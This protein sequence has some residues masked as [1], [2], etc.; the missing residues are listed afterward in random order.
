MI[1]QLICCDEMMKH[2]VKISHCHIP[3]HSVQYGTRNYIILYRL[4]GM[5]HTGPFRFRPECVLRCGITSTRRRV[6]SSR[7]FNLRLGT[8]TKNIHRHIHRY[9]NTSITKQIYRQHLRQIFGKTC[10]RYALSVSPS[11]CM[12]Q[13]VS[14]DITP[15]GA[16]GAVWGVIRPHNCLVPKMTSK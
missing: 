14:A 7:E 13:P 2:Y 9:I 3:G 16:Q 8:N 6:G 5:V 12:L 4:R 10:P 15:V 1:G 11:G